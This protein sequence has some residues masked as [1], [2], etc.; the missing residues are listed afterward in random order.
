MA[1]GMHIITRTRS[2]EFGRTHAEASGA[3]REWARIIRRKH[4]KSHLEVLK[5]FPGVDFIGSRKA[6]FN[7]CGN[8]YRL[9]VDMRYD[10]QRIYVRHVVTHAEYDRLI[11]RGLL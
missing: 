8:A 9:V 11:K 6:V 10:L 3:L 2:T 4:Y 5:D 1:K 7:I